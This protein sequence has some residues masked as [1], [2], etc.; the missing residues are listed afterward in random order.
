[1][2]ELE[3]NKEIQA[4]I[5][6]KMN[7]VLTSIKNRLGYKYQQAFD[8]TQNSNAEFRAFQEL[9]EIFK[10]EMYLP[11]PYDNMSEEKKRKAKDKAVDKI[12]DSF[13]L[14]GYEYE[15]KIRTIVSAIEMAQNW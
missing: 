1:M 15:M 6:F 11:T 8:M 7:E 12:V 3:I 5:E 2:T 9:S 4:R 14:R 10:K 13:E